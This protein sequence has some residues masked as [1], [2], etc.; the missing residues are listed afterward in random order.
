MTILR[1]TLAP[2]VVAILLTQGAAAQGNENAIT[3]GVA[4]SLHSDVLGEDRLLLIHTPQSYDRG[5]AGGSADGAGERFPVIYLLDG[6]G[7]F[8]HTTGLLQYLSA[9]SRMPEA[10][11]VAIPNTDRTRDLTPPLSVADT[12]EFPGAGGADAFL[13]FF[14]EELI[15]FIDAEYR[16]APYRILI[17]HSFGGLFAVYALLE[18][19]DL[20]QA[21]IAISPSLWWDEEALVAQAADFFGDGNE[22]RGF[23][24]M[25]MGNEG[26]GMIAGAWGLTRILETQASPQ[27]HW[28]FRVFDAEDHGSVPHRSTYAAF[29]AIF[30]DW[31]IQ[32]PLA[33]ADDG[34]LSRIDA[35]YAALSER[36]GYE[37]RTPEL[38]I[39]RVGYGLIPEQPDAAIAVFEENMRRYPA[40]ANVYDSLGD[41]Y[42]A[43]GRYEEALRSYARAVELAEAENHPNL[44]LY[45]ANLERMEA[46]LRQ[47]R[48]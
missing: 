14:E 26:G 40:S 36:F 46:T 20:F 43:A 47:G 18:Q 13:R 3:I 19:P 42:D 37:I 11:V 15:P 12:G 28:E 8:H 30:A 35:H 6:D 38:L 16:T 29:E 41:G 5:R 27:F 33:L 23:L 24:Y 21:H 7:H 31:N 44:T 4:R 25:T 17:G 34:D 39:N 48:P 1:R 45:R 9:L 10:I 32:D 22:R 2:A